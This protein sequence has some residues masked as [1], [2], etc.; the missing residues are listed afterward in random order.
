[1]SQL[2]PGRFVSLDGKINEVLAAVGYMPPALAGAM[3]GRVFD[4][5]SHVRRSTI[6]HYKGPGGRGAQRMI[7]SRLHRHAGLKQGGEAPISLEGIAGEVFAAAQSGKT[8]GP[9]ALGQLEF[10]GTVMASD[11][12]VIPFTYGAGRF[13]ARSGDL[14]GMQ[15][16]RLQRAI[17]EGNTFLQKTRD[18]RLLVMLKHKKEEKKSIIL[19]MVAAG[20]KQRPLLGFNAAFERVLPRQ[21]EKIDNVFEQA[22]TATGQA[23]MAREVNANLVAGKAFNRA[24][25]EMVSGGA[26]AAD[27]RKVAKAAAAEAKKEALADKEGGR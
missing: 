5:V 27:A 21:Q 10:G 2:S 13:R 26:K 15:E 14:A 6:S 25:K 17:R 7:A 8:F 19:G 12:F 3:Q 1:M 22:M 9:N 23:R 4:L 18:G 20:R 24:F 11:P 16:S